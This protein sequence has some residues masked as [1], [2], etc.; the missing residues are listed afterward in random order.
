MLLLIWQLGKLQ[1]NVLQSTPVEYQGLI[2]LLG[3]AGMIRRMTEYMGYPG[4]Y[5]CKSC[6]RPRI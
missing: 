6:P 2:G 3:R 5:L 4:N 1:P